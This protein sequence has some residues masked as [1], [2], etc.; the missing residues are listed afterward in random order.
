[1]RIRRAAVRGW[2]G[3]LVLGLLLVGCVGPSKE[4]GGGD[5]SASA[6]TVAN[7]GRGSVS[8]GRTAVRSADA[9]QEFTITPRPLAD[10]EKAALAAL[11]GLPLAAGQP[12]DI[13]SPSAL[14]AEGVTITRTYAQPL[15]EGTAAT[16]A[17]FDPDPGVW[18]AAQSTLS[19]DRRS[20][21]A[22][23]HHLSLWTDLVSGTQ[24]V[25]D[26]MRTQ[27]T[28]AVE[29]AYWGVGKVFDVRVDPPACDAGQPSWVKSTTFIKTDKVNPILFCVGQDQNNPGVLVVKARVNRG[30]GYRAV[31][32]G[33]PSWTSNST[34]DP[35]GLE[36][37]I[38][39][40]C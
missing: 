20:V 33:T 32:N 26:S 19:P 38:D 6:A 35:K 4:G 37:V 10:A 36:Q 3:L 8:V 2:V 13:T 16:L 29:W 27:V 7:S 34:F 15:P 21:S 28:D 12:A 23:V 30:F 1:M 18:F 22:V 14:P 40:V 31:V 39:T 17:F 25:I 9:T 11:Q 5:P 24:S